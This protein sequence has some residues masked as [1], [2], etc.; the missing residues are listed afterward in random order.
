MENS[1]ERQVWQRVLASSGEQPHAD[2]RELMAWVVELLSVYRHLT[3]AASGPRRESLR[4]LYEGEKSNLGCLKGISVLSGGGGE[5][6]KLWEPTKEPERKLLIRCYHRTRRCMVD[7]MSRS[8]EPEFGTV[9]RTL[10]DRAGEH[11]VLIAE[12]L[13]GNV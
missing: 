12:L 5:V 13:G 4:R 10:A 6:L 11:C 3:A 1:K 9:F 2:L 8:A 7:Y